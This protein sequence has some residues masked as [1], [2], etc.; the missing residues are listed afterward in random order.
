MPQIT[1]SLLHDK[2]ERE[3]LRPWVNE[4]LSA[5]GRMD[6]VCQTI[7]KPVLMLVAERF[8]QDTTNETHLTQEH[9][10]RTVDR[11]LHEAMY[12][13]LSSAS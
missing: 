6:T 3:V 5:N 4:H 2:F 10:T 9:L 7:L 12:A 11:L 13:A 1:T 8:L